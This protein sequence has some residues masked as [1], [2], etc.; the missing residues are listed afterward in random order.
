MS[1]MKAEVVKWRSMIAV[2]FMS[3]SP[4]ITWRRRQR[5]P[6]AWGS[7]RVLRI[8]VSCMVSPLITWDV[9]KAMGERTYFPRTMSP[10]PV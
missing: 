5:R 9:R 3:A 1:W 4:T 8:P 6:S 2:S 10:A 7:S